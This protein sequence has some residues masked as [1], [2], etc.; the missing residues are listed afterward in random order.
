MAKVGF[1][2]IWM[3]KNPTNEDDYRQLKTLID[4]VQKFWLVY[5]KTKN[6]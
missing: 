3:K 1:W 2:T 5:W 4:V 6:V